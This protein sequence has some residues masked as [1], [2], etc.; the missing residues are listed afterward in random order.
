MAKKEVERV[1]HIST[2]QCRLFE[3]KMLKAEFERQPPRLRAQTIARV[4]ATLK[5]EAKSGQR[6]HSALWNL[7]DIYLGEQA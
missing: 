4:R 3:R 6:S 2:S 7:R 1:C 5:A